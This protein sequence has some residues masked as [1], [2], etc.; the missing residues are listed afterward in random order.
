[1]TYQH[2]GE[3]EWE[4]GDELYFRDDHPY[5]R[6]LFNFRT[7]PGTTDSCHCSDAASWPEPRGNHL[8]SE[9]D[10]LAEAFERIRAEERVAAM[11]DAA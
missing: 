9:K 4:S 11:G 2:D 10:D 8:L 7:D 3:I 5:S 1:M 6:Y